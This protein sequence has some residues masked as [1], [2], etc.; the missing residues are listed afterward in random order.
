MASTDAVSAKSCD[1]TFERLL[2]QGLSPEELFKHVS[3]QHVEIVLTAHPTQVNRRTLQYK[4]T[5]IATFLERY[6]RTDVSSYDKE[7]ILEDLAREI[8]SLWQT[9]EL[10]RRKPTPLDEARGGLH[11]IEQSLWVR[12]CVARHRV[13]CSGWVARGGRRLRAGCRE[14]HRP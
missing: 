13:S 3:T 10:R 2:N 6:D 11:I 9:D 8:L 14:M 1:A 4:F 12:A 5:R 7:Q